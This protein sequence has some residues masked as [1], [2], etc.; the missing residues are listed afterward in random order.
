[1]KDFDKVVDRRSTA[2]LKWDVKENELPMWVADMDFE[3][4][5]AVTEALAERVRHGVFGYN[6]V[7]LEWY[8]AY[9]KWWGVRY[10]FDINRNWMI[11]CTGI[12]PAISNMVRSLTKEGD[13]VLL[14]T[15]VYNIFFN[16]ILDNGRQVLESPLIYD[17]E[18]YKIDFERLESDLSDPE[19][20]LMILC[21]PHN[22]VGRIWKREDLE[23]IGKLCLKYGVTVIA[24]E[25]HCDLTDPGK[26]YVPFASVSEDC[27]MNSV[28]CVA[29]TKTFNIAGIQTAAVIVP[30]ES[31]RRKVK[32]GFD[33]D[34][35]SEPNSFAVTAAV[36][37]YSHGEKWLEGL[38]HYIFENKKRVCEFLEKELP[39]ISLTKSEATYL[40]WLDC[41][42][43][44][45]N[46]DFLARFIREETGL[47]LI[48]GGAYGSGG[49]AFLRLNAACPRELLDD[50]LKR[51]H[52]GV[53]AFEIKKGIG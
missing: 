27:G 14:Q 36:A 33:T 35:L 20:S 19:T 40:L 24:D 32:R 28:T 1:M 13:K 34:E 17:G 43:V 52:E 11:F 3:T 31:L 45:D 44:T 12:V 10:G 41:G 26:E 8:D 50:G 51:L 37:A 4:V 48:R 23:R 25:I 22:P 6:I 16:C 21:N 46:T 53:K 2:S 29:P 38:R 15:P 49:E 39:E 5:P 18:S 7:P 30:S 47:F 9:K 42:R